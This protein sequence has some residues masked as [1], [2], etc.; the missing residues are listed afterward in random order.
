[1]LH[2]RK[3]YLQ[4]QNYFFFQTN[5]RFANL[6][7]AHYTKLLYI[8][9]WFKPK[10]TNKYNDATQVVHTRQ[11]KLSTSHFQ[12]W[13]SH[14][15]IQKPL[16]INKLTSKKQFRHFPTQKESSLSK[17][18]HNWNALPESPVPHYYM[19]RTGNQWLRSRTTHCPAI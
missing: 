9:I 14:N 18:S 7:K 3:I 19:I 15:Q 5:K 6:F 17:K 2:R 12:F 11:S 10:Q 13:A 4:R 16:T 1:V 8:P